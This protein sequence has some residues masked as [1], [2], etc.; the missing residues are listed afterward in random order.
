M[1]LPTLVL[2][3]TLLFI[4]Y[5]S[6]QAEA[7]HNTIKELQ[8]LSAII[9]SEARGEP[10]IGMVAVAHASINRSKRSDRSICKIKGVTRKTPTLKLQQYFKQIAKTAM[11]THSTIGKADSWNTGKKPH[12]R[13]DKVKVIAR[14]VYY[15]MSSL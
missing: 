15:V 12:S 8:C 13:G 6:A 5:Q 11:S 9:Y 2:S 14:H 1:N 3:T 7:R 4:P 10:E